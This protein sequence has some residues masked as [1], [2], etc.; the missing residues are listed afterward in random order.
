M[1]QSAGTAEAAA[2]MT[3]NPQDCKHSHQ[4]AIVE[5]RWATIGFY[6]G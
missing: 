3:K 5:T 2:T 4:C 6:F 1:A